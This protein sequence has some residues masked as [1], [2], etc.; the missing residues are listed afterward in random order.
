[1]DSKNELLLAVREAKKHLREGTDIRVT[2]ALAVFESIAPFLDKEAVIRMKCQGCD[3]YSM[4][5]FPLENDFC[6]V[7]SSEYCHAKSASLKNLTALKLAG[8]IEHSQSAQ[9]ELSNLASTLLQEDLKPAFVER[10]LYDRKKFASYR[11]DFRMQPGKGNVAI[12]FGHKTEDGFVGGNIKLYI[13][14]R[15]D[16]GFDAEACKGIAR[17]LQRG[18]A[19]V[20]EASQ[21]MRTQLDIDYMLEWIAEKRKMDIVYL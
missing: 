14:R 1:M 6:A 2:D 17:A 7:D 15:L 11:V 12:E 8:C 16:P 3:H 10:K 20:V 19:M 4:A 5:S 21:Q 9:E 13:F 18:P